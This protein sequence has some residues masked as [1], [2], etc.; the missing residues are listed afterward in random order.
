M[1]YRYSLEYL[2]KL[3]RDSSRKVTIEESLYWPQSCINRCLKKQ[4]ARLK[5][6][7]WSLCWHMLRT[8]GSR[9]RWTVCRM[10]RNLFL[11]SQIACP[12]PWA[13]FN[14][15]SSLRKTMRVP[16]RFSTLPLSL[17]CSTLT[18]SSHWFTR[19]PPVMTL[20]MSSSSSSHRPLTM[21]SGP[22]KPRLTSFSSYWRKQR[23]G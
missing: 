7:R 15:S 19:C 2:R 17:T 8:I 4:E 16:H 10:S 12:P 1:P 6:R 14:S 23:K 18:T 5:A 9:R 21:P 13:S 3:L 22:R 11:I 20:W